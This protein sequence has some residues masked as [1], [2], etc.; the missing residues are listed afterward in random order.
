MISFF[1]ISCAPKHPETP[2]SETDFQNQLKKA[3]ISLLEKLKTEKIER[4]AVLNFPENYKQNTQ[5]SKYISES[6]TTELSA[7]AS[8]NVVERNL[9]N[10]V[11]DQ[12]KEN[13]RD[14]VDETKTVELGKILPVEAIITGSYSRV[15]D[16]V[17]LTL[18]AINLTTAMAIMAQTV[19]IKLNKEFIALASIAQDA[20][21]ADYSKIE[22]KAALPPINLNLIIEGM[23]RG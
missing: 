3:S 20:E 18:K 23:S 16:K 4:I 19:E 7:D 11:I 6:L 2:P 21:K 14:V 17:F 12:Q 10:L 13:L 8:I 22:E 1:L 15:E 5:L 9:L